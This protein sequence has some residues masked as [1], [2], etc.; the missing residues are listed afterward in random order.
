MST[1][2]SDAKDK[3]EQDQTWR[4]YNIHGEA[5]EQGA[6]DLFAPPPD[7]HVF[8][9]QYAGV[10]RLALHGHAAYTHSTGLT[11]WKGAEVLADYL[12]AHGRVRG[13]RVVE[14][15]AGLGLCGLAAYHLGA[16]AV[17]LTDGDVQVLE[18]LRRNM[19]QNT[20][21]QTDNDT[22]CPPRTMACPQLI[23][24]TAPAKDFLRVHG[25]A[26]VILAADCLYMAPSVEP[27]FQTVHAL[28]ASDG[29]LLYCNL[30]ATQAPDILLE[31]TAAKYG[32][33]QTVSPHDDRVYI[34]E[35]LT[36]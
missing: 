10:P 14:L 1:S 4:E 32:F 11:V 28:L 5:D 17:Y 8:C 31:R 20:G 2:S 6:F 13:Q 30:C 35:K 36:G 21:T 22:S 34:F 9:Y 16:A 33:G 29:R 18:Q 12:V 27:F 19:A 7:P 26:D 3:T 15:G 25:A 23:W 24:G